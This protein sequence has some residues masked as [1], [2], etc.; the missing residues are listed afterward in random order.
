MEYNELL[1]AVQDVFN[2]ANKSEFCI[3][4]SV[5]KDLLFLIIYVLDNNYVEF[6]G[7]YFKQIIRSNRRQCPH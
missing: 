2:N 5:V 3:P 7:K 1:N 4:H 6:D